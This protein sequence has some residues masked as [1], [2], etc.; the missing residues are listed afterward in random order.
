MNIAQ[1]LVATLLLFLTVQ[2]V[3]MASKPVAG[4]ALTGFDALNVAGRQRMLSQRVVKLYCQLQLGVRSVASNHALDEAISTFDEQLV[5][6]RSASKNTEMQQTLQN[7]VHVWNEMKLV[8]QKD[9]SIENIK[10]LAEI[11][12]NLLEISQ[13]FVILLGKYHHQNGYEWIEKSGRQRMLSQRM[14]KF[15]M[16]KRLGLAHA[17]AGAEIDKARNEFNRIHTS[18]M[19]GAQN[20]PD[21]VDKLQYVQTQWDQLKA[22]LEGDK[23]SDEDRVAAISDRILAGMEQV[24]DLF[25]EAYDTDD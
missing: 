22:A 23:K 5:A 17:N 18:L 9:P 7:Q 12:E 13:K 1:R 10:N 21:I 3:A 25:E 19:Y 15:Y 6:L 11:S 2:G 14:A 4:Q 16:L 20:N 8:L 24:T